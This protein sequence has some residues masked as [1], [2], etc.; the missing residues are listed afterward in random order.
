MGDSSGKQHWAA[1]AHAL[2]PERINPAPSWY[3]RAGEHDASHAAAGLS[4]DC[5]EPR[6]KHKE[7]IG[8]FSISRN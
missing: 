2:V 5:Q 4:T 7:K 3:Q 8:F 6:R 1:E